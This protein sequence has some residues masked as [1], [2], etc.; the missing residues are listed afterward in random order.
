MRKQ[1]LFS[2]MLML[3]VLGGL[4]FCPATAMSSDRKSISAARPDHQSEWP[5]R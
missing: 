4:S 1:V 2:V 5:G 3:G